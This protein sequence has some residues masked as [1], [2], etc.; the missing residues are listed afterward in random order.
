MGIAV[1]AAAAAAVIVALVDDDDGG[2]SG[3]RVS[4]LAGGAP[5][6]PERSCFG[7]HPVDGRPTTFTC[8]PRAGLSFAIV[9]VRPGARVPL[10]A[11]PRG[12]TIATIG[13]R[14]EF[15]SPLSYSVARRHGPWLGVVTPVRPNGRLGWIRFDAADL[16]LYWTRYSL[17]ADLARQRLELRYGRRVLGRFPITIGAAG[18]STPAGRFA[19]TDGLLYGDSPYYGC[20][21]LALSGRQPDLP[22]GWL[23]GDRIAIHGTAG[24]VGGAAS[25]GCLR[26]SNAS[27]RR[28][29][30]HVPLGTP[31][32]IRE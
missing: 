19:I 29:M 23:G 15:D 24:P 9:R 26:A 30:A 14:T 22:P 8:R 2:R 4:T 13:S 6:R 28:L 10:R 7:L 21:A 25:S 20:C 27:M 31:V 16:W 17:R 18:T 32:F 5:S 12:R 3:P 11:A 1:L